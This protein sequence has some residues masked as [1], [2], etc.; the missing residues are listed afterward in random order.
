[1]KQELQNLI[2]ADTWAK[3]NLTHDFKVNAAGFIDDEI[4]TSG[5][6]LLNRLLQVDSKHEQIREILGENILSTVI[7]YGDDTGIPWGHPSYGFY[8]PN[9]FQRYIIQ[10]IMDYR[11]GPQLLSPKLLSNLNDRFDI[12]LPKLGMLSQFHTEYEKLSKKIKHTIAQNFVDNQ[13]QNLQAKPAD[14]SK[15]R[16][17]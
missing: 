1:M 8:H 15:Y 11:N 6:S 4:G 9:I 16:L 13:Q 7:K 3:V 2:P 14:K 10:M 5:I 12:D 17:K